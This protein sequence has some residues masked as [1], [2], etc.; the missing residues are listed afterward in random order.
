MKAIAEAGHLH[1]QLS[2]R[3]PLHGAP[4]V[5]SIIS[6][7]TGT[8]LPRTW[9][10]THTVCVVRTVLY[11]PLYSACFIPCGVIMGWYKAVQYTQ[12]HYEGYIYIDTTSLV[13][14]KLLGWCTICV[15]TIIW[16]IT[17]CSFHYVIID[18]F[19]LSI[20][21][22]LTCGFSFLFKEAAAQ[23]TLVT[24]ALMPAVLG[25]DI[26]CAVVTLLPT[27]LHSRNMYYI[28]LTYQHRYIFV[29]CVC[30]CTI[31]TALELFA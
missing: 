4:I 18:T 9:R 28:V 1:S 22:I 26:A 31:V 16:L 14:V 11:V 15:H 6:S 7:V 19:Q 3:H 5:A 29:M 24:A 2:Y 12:Y 30:Y 27:S 25:Y 8:L 13:H 17:C 23:N 20:G 21:L 10:T